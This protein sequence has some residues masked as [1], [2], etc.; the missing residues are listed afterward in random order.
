DFN[1]AIAQDPL[2][3]ASASA[4]YGAPGRSISRLQHSVIA[5]KANERLGGKREHLLDRR[6]PDSGA[7]GNDV[8]IDE[9]VRI[10]FGREKIAQC[11]ACRIGR[12]TL[13]RRSEETQKAGNEAPV[14]GSNNIA[15]LT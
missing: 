1:P 10:T 12:D 5:V 15:W 9:C 7:H 3:I 8:S 4:A 13:F 14:F 11:N 6:G 2:D